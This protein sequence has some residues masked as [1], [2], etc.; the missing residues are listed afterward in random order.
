MW[1]SLLLVLS[2]W[3]NCSVL[4]QTV[5]Y[6]TD[7]YGNVYSSTVYDSAASAATTTATSLSSLS[8]LDTAATTTAAAYP[9]STTLYSS[10]TTASTFDGST[11]S[12]GP[13]NTSTSVPAIQTVP[14]TG[15]ALLVG[16]CG[17]PQFTI[18]NFPNGGSLEVPLVGCS[19]D[20]P[21]CC[22]SLNFTEFKPSQTG[23]GSDDGDASSSESSPTTSWTGTTPSPTPTGVVS[24]LSAAP[25]T[26]CPSDM[27]DLDPVCCPS[28]FT[29]YGQSIIGN[30]PC[31]STLTTTVYSP[32]PSVLS[33]IT[34]VISASMAAAS[35]TTTPTVSVIINQVFALG[36][37]CADNAEGES[38]K[39]KTHLST[40]A[41]AG[42]GAG[43][44]VAGILLI[45][46]LWACLAVRHRRRKKMRALEAAAT[47]A[48]GPIR[49]GVVVDSAVAAPPGASAYTAAA[50]QNPNGDFDFNNDK[51]KHMSTATTISPPLPGSP[52]HPQQQQMSYNNT[53]MG[54]GGGGGGIYGQPQPPQH[55]YSPAFGY[56]Q[57]HRPEDP[58]GVPV[59]GVPFGGGGPGYYPPTSQSPPPPPPMYP[60]GGYYAAAT[61]GPHSPALPLPAEVDGGGG[62]GG[63]LFDAS[64]SHPRRTSASTATA[65]NTNTNNTTV[66]GPTSA[67]TGSAAPVGQSDPTAA[68]AELGDGS[69]YSRHA[70]QQQQQQQQQ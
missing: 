1:S 43:V 36:L 21:E 3:L 24:M 62:G 57:Y 13:S 14:F 9:S 53:Y 18:I 20:R 69:S 39:D 51:L 41:K 70:Y 23:S 5:E 59:G 56:P 42:I 58:Y 44:G 31:V 32:A 64:N 8:S 37:P 63:G 52:R 49:P 38:G 60:Q 10:Y 28:G 4:A 17:I 2:L 47:A 45:L 66:S 61:G 50:G 16:T 68:V 22:P 7:S 27:V 30:Q 34:S 67:S 25:L 40:G 33:S 11:T 35:T 12:P 26:V 29:H 48:G 55:G 65:V 19:D 54:G 6:S 15:Q 46:G